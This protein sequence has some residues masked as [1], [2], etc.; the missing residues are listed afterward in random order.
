M[1][2]YVNMFLK[3][4]TAIVTFD[5]ENAPYFVM[6]TGTDVLRKKNIFN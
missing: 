3:I 4:A 6:V 5:L 2:K 1:L